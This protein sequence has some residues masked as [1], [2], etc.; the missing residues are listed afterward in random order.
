M[1]FPLLVVGM[2]R[3]KLSAMTR[4]GEEND[5]RSTKHDARSNTMI[6]FS[7]FSFDIVF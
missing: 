6:I 2:H 3:D 7:L 4:G 5:K 1:P